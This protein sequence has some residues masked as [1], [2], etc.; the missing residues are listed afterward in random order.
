VIYFISPETLPETVVKSIPSGKPSIIMLAGVVEASRRLEF[1]ER[2]RSTA[3]PAL[4]IDEALIAF[5]ATKR[6]TRARTVFECGLPYGRVE[7]YTTDAGNLPREM[8]F[9]RKEEIRKIL[10]R[11]ADGC[12]VYGG[13]QLGKSVLLSHVSNTHHEP[14]QDRYIFN[15]VIKPLGDSEET[16]KIWR[17]IA[18]ILPDEI[19]RPGSLGAEEVTRDIIA[20]LNRHPGGQIICL[21]DEADNFMAKDTRDGYRE[22]T[23]LKDLMEK[24]QRAFK[25]VFAGL[26]NVQRMHNQPNSPLWHLGEPICIGPLNRTIDDKRAAFDLVVS[27]MRAAG[28]GFEKRESVEEILAWANYYPSLVQEYMKGL[29]ATLHGSGSGKPYKLSGDGP[30]WKIK[31]DELFNH[32]GFEEIESR[33]RKKF[34]MTLDLDPR[35]ALIAYTLARLIADGEERSAL[36]TGLTPDQLL[37]EAVPY[38]PETSEEP[39]IPAFEVLLEELFDLGVLGRRAVADTRNRFTYLLRTREV[40]AMLGT[41]AD[42]SQALDRIQKTEPSSAYDRVTHRRRY[43]AKPNLERADW[44][45]APLTDHQIEQLTL[46]DN[47]PLQIICG[48]EILGLNKVA[49]SLK[50]ISEVGNFPGIREADKISVEEAASESELRRIVDRKRPS[51]DHVTILIYQPNEVNDVQRKIDWLE[52]QQSVLSRAV[53]PLIILSATNSDLRSLANRRLDQSQ[54]LMPWS[55]EMIRVHLDE[56]EKTHLDTRELRHAILEATGGIPSE[57]QKLITAMIQSEAPA[58]TATNWSINASLPVD[59]FDEVVQT[60]LTIMD[61]DGSYAD[62]NEMLYSETGKDF[63]TIGPDLRAT[64]IVSGRRKKDNPFVLSSFGRFLA[65][66]VT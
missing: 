8:F 50:R 4:L 64:G 2:L 32:R 26:H 30:L 36:V 34:H 12:L 6:E 31:S 24:T 45:Y 57:V 40:A 16:S 23:K 5:T 27:P 39:N 10:D 7:P 65:N 54:F 11:T 9:G 15:M 60:A 28:F 35:Y 1:A 19:V 44:S 49:S 48:L 37:S 41:G 38:W 22:L 17:D 21:F 63:E 33:I 61:M 18:G 53:R 43:P 20:W 52:K 55:A 13:R 58:E 25:V 29:L 62:K 56:L 47:S 46:N 51:K 66:S 14:D 3:K 59:F 42:I